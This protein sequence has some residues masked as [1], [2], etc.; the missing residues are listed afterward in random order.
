MELGKRVAEQPD[1]LN[2]GDAVPGSIAGL[3]ELV[4]ST[5]CTARTAGN[6]VP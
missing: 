3:T 4:S 2:I 5:G 6:T 1:Q